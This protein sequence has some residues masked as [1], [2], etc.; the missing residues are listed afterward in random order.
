[1]AFPAPP[2]DAASRLTKKSSWRACSGPPT[3]DRLSSDP[4]LTILTAVGGKRHRIVLIKVTVESWLH[5]EVNGYG[6]A[7]E[8]WRSAATGAPVKTMPSA[9]L[10][11]VLRRG[12]Y[13]WWI[14]RVYASASKVASKKQA[15]ERSTKKAAS[16][17][18]AK[19]PRGRRG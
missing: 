17:K 12:A 14:C 3:V 19:E 10:G 7:V 4:I 6:E 11:A 9:S 18:P 8:A 2:D 13:G 15:A 1:M 16:K 5:L